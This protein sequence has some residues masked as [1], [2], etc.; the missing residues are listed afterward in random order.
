MGEVLSRM[1][2]VMGSSL[3]FAYA[4][5]L[6]MGMAESIWTPCSVISADR[7]RGTES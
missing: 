2:R 5:Y 3:L 1:V 7:A 6:F 4:S